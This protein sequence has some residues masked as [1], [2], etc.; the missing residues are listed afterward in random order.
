MEFEKLKINVS[1]SEETA[2]YEADRAVMVL[3]NW[4]EKGEVHTQLVANT[5][6]PSVFALVISACAAKLEDSDSEVAQ[7][8]GSVVRQGV[9]QVHEVAKVAAEQAAKETGVSV[10]ELKERFRS[11]SKDLDSA[12]EAKDVN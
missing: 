10:E 6:V 8:M 1:N 11:D 9:D 5:D 7:M 12:E 3:L 4:D 2:S